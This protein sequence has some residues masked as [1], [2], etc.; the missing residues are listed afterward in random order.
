[1]KSKAKAPK[2]KPRPAGGG[3]EVRAGLGE[4]KVCDRCGARNAVAATT[5][6]ACESNRFA[7]PWVRALRRVNR[8]FAV[9]VTDPHPSAEAPEGAR[10]TLYKWW[11]GNNA[12]FNI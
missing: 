8:N 1:M 3:G 2:Q 7:P 9:Q 12:T 6:S 10:L 11:P 4:A 5:C